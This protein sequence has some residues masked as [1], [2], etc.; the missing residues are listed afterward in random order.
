MSLRTKEK[1]VKAFTE[2]RDNI[3]TQEGKSKWGLLFRGRKRCMS[4]PYLSFLEPRTRGQNGKKRKTVRKGRGK[5]EMG[6]GTTQVKVVV[7]N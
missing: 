2:A 7:S 1:M 6:E 4:K 5:I 3:E